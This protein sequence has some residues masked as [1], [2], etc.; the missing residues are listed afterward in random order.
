[1]IHLYGIPNCSSVKKGRARLEADGL[2]HVFHDFRKEG[3]DPSDLEKWIDA[4]G[5]E[6]LVNKR[7]TG[8]RNLDDEVK[9]RVLASD[10]AMK[11]L[12][13]EKP[14]LIKRPVVVFESGAVV[15]GLDEK[16]WSDAAA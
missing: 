7:G 4:V 14:V 13:L 5:L 15:V 12:L 10:E 6:V 9:A 8:W 11:A 16:A 2:E 3:L 1:M